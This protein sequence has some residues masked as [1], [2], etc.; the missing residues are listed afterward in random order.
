[1]DGDLSQY[2]VMERIRN[3]SF[4]SVVFDPAKEKLIERPAIGELGVFG[5]YVAVGKTLNTP[6]RDAVISQNVVMNRSMGFLL[7]SKAETTKQGGVFLGH[8]VVDAPFLY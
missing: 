7:R 2:I 4:P 6:K 3:P 1:M 8:A 5:A